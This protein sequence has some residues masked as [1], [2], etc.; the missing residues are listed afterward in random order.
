MAGGCARPA[1]VA[2]GLL[3]RADVRVVVHVG[4]EPNLFPATY[5]RLAD[6]VRT[7]KEGTSVSSIGRRLVS[8]IVH[9][10]WLAAIL[11][12]QASLLRAPT[13][14]HITLEDWLLDNIPST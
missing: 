3:E 8:G 5:K 14:V 10:S 12:S 9:R 2:D 7:Q 6:N 11:P 13:L 1:P 4:P